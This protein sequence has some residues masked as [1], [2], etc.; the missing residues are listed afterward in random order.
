MTAEP[1]APSPTLQGRR[2]LLT[3]DGTP[4]TNDAAQLSRTLAKRAGTRLHVVA[5]D[6]GEAPLAIGHEGIWRRV[7][8]LDHEDAAS[9][10]ARVRQR[11]AEPLGNAEWDLSV[12]EGV[13]A[14]VI[15]AVA[16]EI[17]A[18]LIVMGGSHSRT[19]RHMLG[20]ALALQVARLSLAPVLVVSADMGHAS[21]HTAVVAV[22]FSAASVVSARAAMALLVAGPA[23]PA[24]L[25]LLH[26][27]SHAP[28]DQDRD[29]DL[30][31]DARVGRQFTY[32]EG[33]LQQGLS[34]DVQVERVVRAGDVG[35]TIRAVAADRHAQLVA[36]GTHGRGF[37]ERLFLGSVAIT[38]LRE[39]ETS[40]L[41]APAP[42][43]AERLRL[44][45]VLWE[46]VKLDRPE[47]WG[48]ALE[49]FSERNTGRLAR[50]EL[51]DSLA[52]ATQVHLDAL[53]FIT[54]R[55]D[56]EQ[57]RVELVF[58][59]RDDAKR[60]HTQEVLRVISLEMIGAHGPLD[61]ALLLEH[62]GG[63]CA[64]TFLPDAAGQGV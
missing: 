53:P 45:L 26:V 16:E 14:E 27:L 15:A 35:K 31:V 12:R 38:T 56:A 58:A 19:L 30:I 47:D 5:A 61:H 33:L 46:Q 1:H 13:P 2:I 20:E 4:S 43:L 36:L 44:E 32:L 49:V 7:E 10:Y 48:E 64:L 22:D 54:A 8:D 62:A 50:V 24:R 41:I 55:W 40:V 42:Q 25:I 11:F 51:T 63:R 9:L 6:G 37:L 29:G 34:D 21:P 59:E 39:A 28:K 18:D 17:G 23:N 57:R 3:T 52:G 60:H